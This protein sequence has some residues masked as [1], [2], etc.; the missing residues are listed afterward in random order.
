VAGGTDE[1]IV[2]GCKFLPSPEPTLSSVYS[3]ISAYPGQCDLVVSRTDTSLT[4]LY[5]CREA[6]GQTAEA[7]LT[8]IG[9]LLSMLLGGFTD[10]DNERKTDTI[11]SIVAETL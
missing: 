6:S 8:I 3:L 1:A 4:G 5:T 11:L 10:V 2:A 7:H 9:Q